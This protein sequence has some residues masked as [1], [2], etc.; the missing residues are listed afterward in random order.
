MISFFFVVSAIFSTGD[1]PETC[2]VRRW[3]LCE[4]CCHCTL[5]AGP[6][7]VAWVCPDLPYFYLFLVGRAMNHQTLGAAH[8]QKK[9]VVAGSLIFLKTLV[10]NQGTKPFGS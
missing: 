6:P 8:L 10:L 7:P 5:E 9:A 4:W 3:Q 2:D 1:L